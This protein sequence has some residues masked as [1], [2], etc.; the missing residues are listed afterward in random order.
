MRIEQTPVWVV[1]QMTVPG[2]PGGRGAVCEQTEWDEME[3]VNPGYHTLV[4]S[5]IVNEAEAEL[6]ARSTSGF[7][8]TARSPQLKARV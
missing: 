5:G 7:V 8:A 2:N 1:Y 4:R 6:L 3:R